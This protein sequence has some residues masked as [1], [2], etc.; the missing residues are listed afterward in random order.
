MITS[1]LPWHTVPLGQDETTTCTVIKDRQG[2][3]VS[4]CTNQQDAELIIEAVQHI[5]DDVN[6]YD[7]T[8]NLRELTRHQ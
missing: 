8:P 6:D 7:M 1:P 2:K 5:V 4:F 3:A